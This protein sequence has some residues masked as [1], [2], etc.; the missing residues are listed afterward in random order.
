M[1][2]IQNTKYKK[3]LKGWKNKK[4]IY[5]LV[6]RTWIMFIKLSKD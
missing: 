6:G 2:K 4:Y 3:K 5:T 1:Q